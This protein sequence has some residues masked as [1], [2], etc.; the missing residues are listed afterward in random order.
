MIEAAPRALVPMV[1]AGLRQQCS[2]FVGWSNSNFDSLHI[3]I[4]LETDNTSL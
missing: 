4:S 1:P 2:Q 3:N